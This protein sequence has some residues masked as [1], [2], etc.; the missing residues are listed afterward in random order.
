MAIDQMIRLSTYP[1]FCGSIWG[2]PKRGVPPVII[3]FDRNFHYKPTI[4]GHQNFRK[5]P[6]L[7]ITILQFFWFETFFLHIL[8][9]IIPTNF[10]LFPEGWLND[11]QVY[12]YLY[13]VWFLLLLSC[14]SLLLLLLSWLLLC[15]F[16]YHCL[17]MLIILWFLLLLLWFICIVINYCFCYQH[18]YYNLLD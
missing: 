14:L 12:Y 16:H 8:G 3:Y 7:I 1:S 18:C 15:L 6:F 2:L 4:L 13:N 5:P 17:F 11:Q 10:H 9:V